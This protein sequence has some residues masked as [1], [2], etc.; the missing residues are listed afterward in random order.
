M[1]TCSNGDQRVLSP[2]VEM[3]W[4]EYKEETVVAADR[5]TSAEGAIELLE[6]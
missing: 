2:F 4:G 6:K 3:G 1:C 5:K